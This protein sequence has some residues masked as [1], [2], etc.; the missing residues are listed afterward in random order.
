MIYIS[1]LW[2][3][4]GTSTLPCLLLIQAHLLSLFDNVNRVVFHEK[5]YDQILSFQSQEGETV[6]LTEPVSA[7][8]WGDSY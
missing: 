6:A 5:N 2:L 4:K 1:S 8:V 3:V 7:Q